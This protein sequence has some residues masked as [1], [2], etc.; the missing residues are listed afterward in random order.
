MEDT[1]PPNT[2]FVPFLGQSNA[3]QMSYIYDPYQPGMITNDTSGAIIL[4]Q[5][6]TA[7]IEGNVVTSDTR[8]TNFAVGGSKVDGN[9]YFQDDSTVWWYPD[10]GQPGGALRQ[11]E[12][13]LQ[14]WLS[15]QGAQPTDEIAIVW[16][17]GESDVG[18]VSREDP[19]A[20]EKYKQS[21][22]AIFDD[23]RS[24]LNYADVKFYLVPT[25][26]LQADGAAN[27]GLSPL[28]IEAINKGLAIVR[29]VQKE[30]ATERD[31]VLLATDYSDLNMVYEE[32]TLY[33]ASY[34]LDYS[35]WS[36]DFWHLGHDGLKINGD[37]LAQYIS[38]DRGENNVIS[39]TDSFGNPAQSTSLAR[40]GLLDINVSANP[41]LGVIQGTN[42][43]DVIV[44][45]LAADV[46]AG[47]E[48]NDIIMASQGV[49]TLTGA[50]GSDVFFFDPLIYPGVAS[51][52]DIVT[53][54]ELQS[55][56][57][58]VSELL[59]LTGNPLAETIATQYIIVNPLSETSLEI[60]FDVD[61]TGEQSA[62]TLAILENVSPG[63]FIAEISSHLIVTPTEF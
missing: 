5:K 37:R 8:E 54:F 61:A 58:D 52:S 25:G 16:S 2:L 11:A 40:A 33:G 13:G 55:D 32:G 41:S 34:D 30:I 29:E 7:L 36:A 62:E 19:V 26:R 27:A 20:R 1:E 21:T 49:D 59:K 6:L 24:Q 18:D 35:E 47:G 51:N 60:K 14:D 46:I 38:L 63:E 10:Q 15:V 31:D 17:Q 3:E 57:L 44:G 50:A 56:R 39:F 22:L 42:N 45:T 43:P 23:L 53:D 9:G 48:G 4:D 28:E 12:Q